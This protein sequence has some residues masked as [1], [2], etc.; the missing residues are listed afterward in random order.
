VHARSAK[1][2]IGWRKKLQVSFLFVA[3]FA[4]TGAHWDVL[5]VVAWGRMIAAN[6]SETMSVGSAVKQT[7]EPGSSCPLCK[8]VSKAKQQ[9]RK[10]EGPLPSEAKAVPKMVLY[11]Q[12]NAVPPTPEVTL[13]S[14]ALVATKVISNGR[15]QPPIP[16]P[17]V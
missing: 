6:Y 10:Q 15:A 9:E 7:F 17:K 5:Q 3:W 11:L 16:P 14:Y 1:A 8:M 2:R 13:Q 12:E 4:A